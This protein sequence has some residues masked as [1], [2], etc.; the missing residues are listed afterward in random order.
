MTGAVL[1]L[2]WILSCRHVF[3]HN[4]CR[5]YW[6]DIIEDRDLLRIERAIHPR[7]A[8]TP[9]NLN[10]VLL[11]Q[12]VNPLLAAWGKQGCDYMGL[13]CSY[14]RPEADLPRLRQW[15]DDSGIRWGLS[16]EQRIWFGLPAGL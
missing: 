3:V 15:I 7:K 8:H 4:P 6:A 14:D 9:E 12:H 5:H 11:H 13:L 2:Q 16:A 1:A 10:Q